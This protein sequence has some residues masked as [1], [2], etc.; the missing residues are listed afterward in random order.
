MSEHPSPSSAGFGSAR[1]D[2][3]ARYFGAFPVN[4]VFSLILVVA[5][6]TLIWWFTKDH[7][8]KAVCGGTLMEPGDL[9]ELRTSN[10]A[11][12]GNTTTYQEELNS[13]R[14]M[15]EAFDHIR[16]AMLISGAAA[17]ALGLVRW[18]QDV[19]LR[20]RLTGSGAPTGLPGGGDAGGAVALAAHSRTP[21]LNPLFLLLGSLGA[22]IAW[23]FLITPRPARTVDS[24]CWASW[25][26][27]WERCCTGRP[28]RRTAP[29]S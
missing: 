23:V 4:I 18:R 16:W 24:C 10:Y 7:V 20:G 27:G 15:F 28:G 5:V 25:P 11:P 2:R 21:T 14:R 6:S 19:V 22:G 29:R 3:Q 17:G 1:V 9:C 13:D 26:V 8:P 12:T